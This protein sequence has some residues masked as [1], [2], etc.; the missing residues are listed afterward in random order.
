VTGI[1][2]LL[3]D[4]GYAL[5]TMRRNPGSAA[6]AVLVLAIG[7]GPTTAMFSVVD[8]VLL[9]PLPYPESDRLVQFIVAS[10]MGNATL[11]SVPKFIAWRE[12]RG[13][14][15]HVAAFTAPEPIVLATGG[16]PE[17]ASGMQVSAGYFPVFGVVTASGRLFS[18][19][20]DLPRGPRV[21]VIS[22]GFWQ[23]RLG[24]DPAALGR[25]VQ[26]DGTPHEVIGI[27]APNAPVDARTD[28][29]MPLQ[30]DPD[31]LDHSSRLQVVG[32]LRRG[33]AVDSAVRQVY[34]SAGEFHRRFPNAM[35]PREHF[36]IMWLRD[37]V[38]GDARPAL[39]FLLGAV[40]VLLL[41]ACANVANLLLA[42]GTAREREFSL[43]AALGARPS[44]ILAQLLTES[45]LVTVIGASLGLAMG[46]A[47]LRWL[48][49]FYPGYLT[50]AGRLSP[51]IALDWRLLGFTAILLVPTTVL[52]GLYPALQSARLD[53][54]SMFG[55]AGGH[56][57]GSPRHTRLRSTLVVAQMACALVLL[58]GAGLFIQAF[59]KT[60]T[61]APG[62]ASDHI[63]TLDMPLSGQRFARTATVA[64]LV[65]TAES[66]IETMPD[67][68][69]AAAASSLPLEPAT[70]LPFVIDRRP[71]LQSPFH[72]SANWRRISPD[73]FEVFRIRLL[74][75]RAF[76]KHDTIDSRP[77]AIVNDSM[78]RRFW[79]NATP[80]DERITIGSGIRPD[81]AEPSRVVVGIVADLR[82]TGLGRNPEPAVYVPIAQ[83]SDGMNAF[84]NAALPLRWVVRTG[85]DPRRLGADI[86]RELRASSGGLPAGRMQTMDEIVALSTARADF[87]TTV[88]TMF[89]AIALSLSCVG[90]YGLMVQS[91]QQRTREIGIR[92]ALGAERWSVLWMVVGD[93]L[94][95]TAAGVVLG[96]IAASVAMQMLVGTIHGIARWDPWVF[97]AVVALLN[98]VAL[99]AVLLSARRATAVQPTEALRHV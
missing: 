92:M 62:F 16:P 75:G 94:R 37:V 20:D 64:G 26:I 3:R 69:M 44:S 57:T 93:G 72:G 29:W 91:I 19:A 40:A 65:Q 48:T 55:S 56:A 85:V 59:I 11:A 43:R 96:V 28:V 45:V 39:L 66:R 70:T 34:S 33:V 21:A 8:K 74:R 95:L 12:G 77:V 17:L 6:I 73:Y 42:R 67:V 51:P 41:I 25:L 71:L 84:Q 10:P 60:R 68:V 52:F 38:V 7:I 14:F 90:L 54:T 18:M 97:A 78:A 99:V 32:R 23:R 63:L 9:Q 31:S 4:L 87:T 30:A 5:R 83:V 22:H 2:R 98:G 35:G 82:D 88:L 24:R 86:A 15:E 27:L 76:T 81:I 53:L 36:G 79:P 46:A 47:G 89:A 61:V 49:S 1:G 13:V 58:V 50:L 80:L